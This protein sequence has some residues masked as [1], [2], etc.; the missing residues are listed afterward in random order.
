MILSGLY[1]YIILLCNIES[2]I[3]KS[4]SIYVTAWRL[5]MNKGQ[6]LPTSYVIVQVLFAFLKHSS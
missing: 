5:R 4:C 3:S 6:G 1:F 2:M